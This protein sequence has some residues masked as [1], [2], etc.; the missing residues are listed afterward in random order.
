MV[1]TF[2]SFSRNPHGDILLIMPGAPSW[3]M[4]VCCFHG[5]D[6]LC[7]SI[8]NVSVR[9]R[10][11]LNV[12][13]RVPRAAYSQLTKVLSSKG[14]RLPLSVA[15][16]CYCETLCCKLPC[17]VSCVIERYRSLSI[18]YCVSA[19]L[20]LVRART[21]QNFFFIV[22]GAWYFHVDTTVVGYVKDTQFFHR[23][24]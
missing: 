14:L 10:I 8:W 23:L 24:Q 15:R 2:V 7:Q 4:S 11:S 16:G 21:Y 1:S 13:D 9:V 18:F 19:V 5:N 3:N 17:A 6:P 20:S 12:R 22:N